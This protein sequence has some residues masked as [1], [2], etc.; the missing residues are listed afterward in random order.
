MEAAR[1]EDFDRLFVFFFPRRPNTITL[2]CIASNEGFEIYGPGAWSY[3]LFNS[4]V[5]DESDVRRVLATENRAVV[6]LRNGSSTRQVVQ[7]R[8]LLPTSNRPSTAP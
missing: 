5:Q 6:A 3:A 1:Q 2:V 8:P 4:E 7:A